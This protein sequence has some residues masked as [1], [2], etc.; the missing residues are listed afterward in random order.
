MLSVLVLLFFVSK[1]Y[2]SRKQYFYLKY[3]H[4]MPSVCSNMHLFSSYRLSTSIRELQNFKA[5]LQH[6]R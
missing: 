6:R 2:S 4:I 3:V 1:L 5:L